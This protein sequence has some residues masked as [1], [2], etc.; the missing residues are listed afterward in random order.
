[1]IIFG[2]TENSTCPFASPRKRKKSKKCM[3]F[4]NI[5]IEQ[6]KLIKLN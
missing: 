2:G 1:M 5:E 4:L 6:I 3:G